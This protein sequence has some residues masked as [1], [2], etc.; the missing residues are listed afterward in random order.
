MMDEEVACMLRITINETPETVAII[1]EGRLAGEWA[2]ELRRAWTEVAERV[3]ARPVS[4]DLR[5]LT[6]ADEDGKRVLREIET[7]TG[8]ALMATTP[9]T[10]H[11]VAEICDKNANK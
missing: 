1:L 3:N 10:K 6:Y 7:Q 5:S 11:L 8:A 9:W 4:V 2:T